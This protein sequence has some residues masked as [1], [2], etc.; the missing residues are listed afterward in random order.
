[1]LGVRYIGTARKQLFF[2]RKF[3]PVI[4]QSVLDQVDLWINANNVEDQ[5]YRNRA[6]VA[7]WEHPS[8][9]RYWQNIYHHLCG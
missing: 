9:T 3:E 8:R 1:M 4:S 7:N 2:G 5:M 6:Q